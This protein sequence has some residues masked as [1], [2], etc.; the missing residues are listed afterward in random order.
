MTFFLLI[1]NNTGLLPSSGYA[2]PPIRSGHLDIKDAQ[3]DKKNDGHK[4]SYHIISRWGTAAVQK[5]RFERPKI[6][7]S[8]KVAKFAG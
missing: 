3:C 1:V 2:D 7:L 6:K 8:S 5:G 4:I